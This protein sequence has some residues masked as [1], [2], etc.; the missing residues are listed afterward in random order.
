M[1]D[2]EQVGLEEAKLSFTGKSLT[3][4]QTEEA[5]A[6]AGVVKREIHK[7]GKFRDKLTNYAIAYSHGEKFDALKG[8]T[9]IR[10][11]FKARYGQTM[12]QMR[13]SL[14]EREA[15]LREAGDTQALHHARSVLTFIKE[16]D[17]MPFYKAYDRAAVDMATRHSITETGAKELMKDAFLQAEG[18][19]LY[20]VCKELEQ[21]FHTPRREAER[22]L[23]QAA[24]APTPR[25]SAPART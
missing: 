17:T 10:D 16:G 4:S 2:A 14:M 18:R 9:I 21:E 20:E 13:E 15:V 8:E 1:T 25:R 19:Q 24:R 23:R 6:D 7:S 3:Q 22:Q 5:W 12:N 11:I